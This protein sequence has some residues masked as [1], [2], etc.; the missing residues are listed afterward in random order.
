MP[1]VSEYT[2]FNKK[3]EGIETHV[4]DEPQLVVDSLGDGVWYVEADW[5]GKRLKSV[6][7]R[8]KVENFKINSEDG[9]Y[10][11][12]LSWGEVPTRVTDYVVVA[13]GYFDNYEISVSEPSLVISTGERAVFSVRT[14]AG[15][16]RTTLTSREREFSPEGVTEVIN[17]RIVSP[18]TSSPLIFEWDPVPLSSSYRVIALINGLPQTL[19]VEEPRLVVKNYTNGLWHV[20]AWW[21]AT[22]IRSKKIL[23]YSG[24]D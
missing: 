20:E 11:I 3:T 5:E 4:V 2:V 1:S 12:T 24:T 8:A 9:F 19:S 21:G 15:S 17:F 7:I 13:R 6:E 22:L 23:T 14:Q 10:P 18:G 16:K